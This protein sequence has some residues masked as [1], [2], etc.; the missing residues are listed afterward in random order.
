MNDLLQIPP[1]E[2]RAAASDLLRLS[3]DVARVQSAVRHHWSRLDAG[4]Q[5][6]ARAGVDAQYHE[7]VREIA[8]MAAMIEQLAQALAKT[9]NAL[10]TAD[11]DATAFFTA[12]EVKPGGGEVSDFVGSPPE[13]GARPGRA[14]GLASPVRA[15]GDPPL[16]TGTFNAPGITATTPLAGTTTQWEFP[17][18]RS[19]PFAPSIY[20]PMRLK[21][22]TL[23][24]TPFNI[25]ALNNNTTQC[26]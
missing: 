10:E 6:Y 12:E 8:R 24:T 5:S 13:A 2:L 21:H 22:S 4:W 16:T 19:T 14:K 23:F 25:E 9:A 11:R 7:T 20:L 18:I 1:E 3:A 15:G 17:P 26:H